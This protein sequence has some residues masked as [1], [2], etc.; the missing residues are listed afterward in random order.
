MGSIRKAPHSGRWEARYR[1]PYGTQRSRTFDRKGDA[2]AF[3]AATET[4]KRHGD[5]FEPETDRVTVREWHARWWLTIES[6]DHAANTL[7]QYEGILRRHVLAQL[8]DRPMASLRRIDLEEWIATLRADGLGQSGVRTARTL[9]GMML[10]SAVESRIIRSNPLAGVKLTRKGPSR[11]KQALTV[12]QVEA[13]ANESGAYR[14]LVLVLSYGGLRPNEAFALRRRHRDDFGQLVIEEG[15]VEVRGR[16]VST[17]GKTHRARV[18]PLPGSVADEFSEHLEARP[19]DP[20]G[21]VFV[22]S[23]GCPIGLRNFR[24]QLDAAALRAGMPEWFT[25]YTLR[26]TCASLMASQGVPVTTAAAIMGHDP[27]MFL[28]TYAHLYPGDMR[29]AAAVLDEARA[30]VLDSSRGADVVQELRSGN[31]S[32]SATS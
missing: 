19:A 9:L 5:W 2:T 15:L 24:R 31:A 23:T 8:G 6:S 32:R 28:R 7:V 16:L 26:H 20:E 11:A 30:T 27:A 22:T 14:V 3:L 1:D 29:E 4:D 10:S 18:V 21:L 25:P 13:L 12:V 17:D